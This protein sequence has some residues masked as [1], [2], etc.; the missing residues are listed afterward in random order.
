[1]HV[2]RALACHAALADIAEETAGRRRYAEAPGE[3][4]A[5]CR[6]P[7]AAGGAAAERLAAC[8]STPVLT[9]HPTEMRRRSIVEREAEIERLMALRRHHHAPALDRRIR[10]NLFREVALLW[11]TRLLRR[12]GSRWRTRSS[13]ALA[14]VERSMLPALRDLYEGWAEAAGGE[15]P[16]ML[17]LGSWLGGDRDGHPGVDA[18]TLRAALG[19]QAAVILK[20]YGA[21]VEALVGD[22]TL[23]SVLAEA[24]PELL[25]LAE[26]SGED[27]VQRKD[28]PYRR[29]LAGVAERLRATA[30]KLADGPV[31]LAEPYADPGA[32]I[33]DLRTVEASL[34]VHG[35]ERLVGSRLKRL[36]QLVPVCGFHLLTLDLR[37][38]ADVHERTVAELFAKAGL[39]SDYLERDE[40]TRVGV[41]LRELAHCRLLRSPYVAYSDETRREL[42]VLDAAR[43]ALA[44]YGAG[45]IGA[46]IASKSSSVSDLL[47]IAV[48]LKQAGLVEGGPQPTAALRIVPLFETIDDLERGPAIIRQWLTLPAVRAMLGE[49][50][51]QEVMLGYSDSNK[52]G[53]FTASRRGA[54]VASAA[55]AAEAERAGVGLQLFH[56][57]GGSIGR[58]GGSAAEAILAQPPGAVRGRIRLT[59][60]G[61]MI[62]R[63]YGD[64]PAARRNLE[65][66]VAATLLASDDSAARDAPTLRGRRRWTRRRRRASARSGRW[67]T[68]TRR[69][70]RSSGR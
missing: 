66:L 33:A 28:E 19:A 46:Y 15:A 21:E 5:P 51:L 12:S 38:N 59:E 31:S 32:F 67:C 58:G 14:I 45:A 65:S 53:G 68:T 57:R 11:R 40:E 41:L 37:Q 1:V 39:L 7:G 69:S 3:G 24:S 8:G 4:C 17:T 52:D 61:E 42:A 44:D 63:K 6:P 70:R 16:T 43:T 49:R 36:L 47:E 56:G 62:A 29:A 13:N 2:A 27:S 18:G 30:A 54:S 35:G 10:E 50:P 64:P 34:A 22:L 20:L 26:R 48:L 55:F 25:A 9:A 60:Q 23:S